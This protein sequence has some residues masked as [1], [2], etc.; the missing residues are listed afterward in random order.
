MAL[1]L[2]LDAVRRRRSQAVRPRALPRALFLA[3]KAWFLTLIV[4]LRGDV[5]AHGDDDWAG[6]Q[7]GILSRW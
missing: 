2:N 3:M 6:E 1:A 4:W 7:Q 5:L